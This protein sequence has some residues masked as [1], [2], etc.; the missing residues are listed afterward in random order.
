MSIDKKEDTNKLNLYL[1]DTKAS[2]GGGGRGEHGMEIGE[3]QIQM[4]AL[5]GL[6]VATPAIICPH[7]S[8]C[9]I[10]TSVVDGF[11]GSFI[12]L[13]NTSSSL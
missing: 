8:N 7:I 9:V 11:H 3:G 12:I 1:F 4:R 6:S 2:R 5:P 10:F 13:I